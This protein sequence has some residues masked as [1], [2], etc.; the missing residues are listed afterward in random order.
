MPGYFCFFS[1]CAG[2][3]FRNIV[4]GVLSSIAIILMRK[5]RNVCVDKMCSMTYLHVEVCA[6]CLSLGEPWVGLWSVIVALSV[7]ITC[8]IVRHGLI[9]YL[10]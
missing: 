10:S 2:S 6:L 5:T 3:V 9:H 4:L 1:F 7:I 8:F